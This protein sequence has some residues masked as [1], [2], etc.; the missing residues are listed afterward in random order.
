MINT[1][2]YIVFHGLKEHGGGAGRVRW[3]GFVVERLVSHREG[4]EMLQ[5]IAGQKK[6]IMRFDDSLDRFIL[7]SE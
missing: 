3:L 2:R 4:F 1:G 7:K 5:M 6:D